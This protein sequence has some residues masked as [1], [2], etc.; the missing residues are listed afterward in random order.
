MY[1]LIDLVQLK[2]KKKREDIEEILTA[3]IEETKRN[4]QEGNDVWWVGLCKFTWK[5]KAKTKKEAKEWTEYPYMALGKLRCIEDESI[6]GL[7][8]KEG[9]MRMEKEHVQVS[10]VETQKNK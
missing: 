6:D 4:L 3:A 5:Q 9:I 7:Q 1:N 8:A 10:V 2:T